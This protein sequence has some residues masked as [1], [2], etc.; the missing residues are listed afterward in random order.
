MITNIKM[1]KIENEAAVAYFEMLFL[2]LCGRE[3]F[4]SR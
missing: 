1:E 2:H 4:Q 3:K